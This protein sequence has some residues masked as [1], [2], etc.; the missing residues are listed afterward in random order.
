MQKP[1]EE[2]VF[3]F[4]FYILLVFQVHSISLN[5]SNHVFQNSHIATKDAWEIL[6]FTLRIIMISLWIKSIIL[7]TLSGGGALE[8]T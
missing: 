1:M 3:P 8:L 4:V 7:G 2:N 5:Y 6:N